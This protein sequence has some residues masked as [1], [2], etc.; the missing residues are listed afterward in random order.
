[1]E[2]RLFVGFTTDVA[3]YPANRLGPRLRNPDGEQD[4]RVYALQ[5]PDNQ[6]E[7]VA[8][9]VIQELKGV[10]KPRA[11]EVELDFPPLKI[12]GSWIDFSARKP[13]AA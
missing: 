9:A 11:R 8:D 12:G 6:R 5:R 10:A 13:A 3:A 4:R 2:S 7:I 1:M